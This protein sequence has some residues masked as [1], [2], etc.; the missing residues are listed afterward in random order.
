MQ[1]LKD[2]RKHKI[3]KAS[4]EEFF[5]NGFEKTSVSAIAKNANVAAGNIYDYFRNKQDLFLAVVEPTMK[6]IDKRMNLLEKRIEL[7]KE[8]I[9]NFTWTKIIINGIVDHLA[10]NKEDMR[11]LLFKSSN[12]FVKQYKEGFVKRSTDLFMQ[13]QSLLTSKYSDIKPM[14]RLM[15]DN[16]SG[17]YIH[18]IEEILAQNLSRKEIKEY[19]D[20]AVT[21]VWHGIQAVLKTE[22]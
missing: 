9:S 11:I 15:A 14:S 18:M 4:K 8:N 7:R 3:L 12:D 16:L 5:K 19:A 6:K 20:E 13:Y 2:A 1:I 22:N 17:F 21:F 10:A